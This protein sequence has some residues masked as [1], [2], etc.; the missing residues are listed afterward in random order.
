M[1]TTQADHREPAVLIFKYL[2]QRV[3]DARKHGRGGHVHDDIRITFQNLT[4]IIND[5]QNKVAYIDVTLKYPLGLIKYAIYR[6][7]NNQRAAGAVNTIVP[8]ITYLVINSPKNANAGM[9]P[10]QAHY[11]DILTPL[12]EQQEIW[13]AIYKYDWTDEIIHSIEDLIRRGTMKIGDGTQMP[14]YPDH[15]GRVVI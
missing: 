8:Q 14:N 6:H 13:T 9:A 15:A 2:V 10:P 3:S 11:A 7:Y 12:A 5:K 1:P 4:P